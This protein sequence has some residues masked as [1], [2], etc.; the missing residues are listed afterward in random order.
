MLCSSGEPW[1]ITA[2]R[3]FPVEVAQKNF[4]TMSQY[5]HFDEEAMVA[6]KGYMQIA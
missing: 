3:S 1:L 4:M 5:L 6:Q 2:L